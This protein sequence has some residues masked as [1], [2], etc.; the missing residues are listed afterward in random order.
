MNISLKISLLLTFFISNFGFAQDLFPVYTDYY[1][2]NMYLIHPANA[3]IGDCTKIRL[4][5]RRQWL[6]YSDAPQFQTLSF[7]TSMGEKNGLGVILFNDKNGYHSQVGAKITYAHHIDLSTYL[8]KNQLSFGLSLTS[9]SNFLDTSDFIIDD[10][11]VFDQ[12]KNKYYHNAD[13]G[14]SYRYFDF[15]SHISITNI[16]KTDL[17]YNYENEPVDLMQYIASFGYNIKLNYNLKFEPSTMIRYVNY[18]QEKFLDLN[19]KAN[20]SY[21]NSEFWG[22]VSYHKGFNIDGLEDSNYLTSLVGINY[23]NFVFS[24]SFTFQHNNTIFPKGD[25]HQITVGANLFCDD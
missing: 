21:E 12:M 18:T 16:L 9:F 4:T 10:P 24:Y 7:H 14:L 11:I 17:F 23:N 13:F 5:A 19:L 2:D 25:F 6:D 20:Y 15:F 3:G 1:A 22:G 8:E